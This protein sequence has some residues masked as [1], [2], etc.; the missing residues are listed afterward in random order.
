LPEAHLLRDLL[1][2]AGIESYVFNENAQSGAGQ[3]PVTETYPEVW[4]AEERD[5]VRAKSVVDQYE[6]KVTQATSESQCTKCG[7]LNPAVFE[8]CWNCGAALAR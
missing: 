2:H 4:I 6:T 1:D 7:E 5:L 8:L 3:L